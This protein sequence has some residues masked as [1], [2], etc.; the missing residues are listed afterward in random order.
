MKKSFSFI[1]VIVMLFTMFIPVSARTGRDYGSIGADTMWNYCSLDDSGYAAQIE[2][3]YE[4][5]LRITATCLLSNNVSI[6]D[7]TGWDI[8][9]YCFM[10]GQGNPTKRI[11]ST[12]YVEN[13]SIF[14][15][16]IA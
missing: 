11:D 12:H 5:E 13:R 6:Y 8:D 16:A 14:L 1:L 15:S 3:T 4:K 10:D 9:F 2:A 7:D